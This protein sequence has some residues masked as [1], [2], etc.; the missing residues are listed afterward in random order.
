MLQRGPAITDMPNVDGFPPKAV[1]SMEILG[2][3][4]DY[5]LNWVEH[6]NNV[7]HSFTTRLCSAADVYTGFVRGPEE[8]VSSPPNQRNYLGRINLGT[9]HE[10]HHRCSSHRC[11]RVCRLVCVEDPGWASLQLDSGQVCRRPFGNTAE[12][13]LETDFWRFPSRLWS[14]SMQGIVH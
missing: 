8:D 13:L 6:V 4:L 2:V 1:E 10:V 3:I 12:Q 11:L 7:S 9:T 14:R 5:H